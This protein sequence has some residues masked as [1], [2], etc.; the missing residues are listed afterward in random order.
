MARLDDF[1]QSPNVE[2]RRT[3]GSKQVA[4]DYPIRVRRNPAAEAAQR[5]LDEMERKKADRPR[6]GRPRNKTKG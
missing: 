4:P 5:R 2:D 6:G 3:R 1:R